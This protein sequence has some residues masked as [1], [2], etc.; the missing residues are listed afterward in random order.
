[1]SGNSRNSLLRTLLHVLV[2]SA[3]LAAL[4]WEVIWQ[5]KSSLALGISAWGTALTLAATMGGMSLGAFVMGNA[6]KN[7]MLVR[8]VRLYGALEFAI[9]VAGLFLGQAFKAVQ[10]LDTWAYTAI[11]GNGSLVH[12][13]G[14]AVV[15]G[16]P[17]M[18]MGA[19]LPVFGL[20]ARQFRTSI[21]T[22]YGLNTL[23][24]ATGSLI[25]AFA[26][27]PLFGIT[28]TGF[29]A[30]G[31]NFAVGVAT[32]LLPPGEPA[33]APVQEEVKSPTA[34]VL[35]PWMQQLIVTVTG[36]A[37][38]VLEIAW[39]R[40]L[41]AAF[42]S[43][44]AAFATMLAAVLI[45]LG[46]AARLAPILKKGNIS[47]GP[48]I[49]W[50]GILI[51]LATPIIERFELFMG[52]TGNPHISVLV[53]NMSRIIMTLCVVGPPVLFLGMA[54]P[55]IIDDTDNAR[56][57]GILY[58]LNTLAAIVGS[59]SAAWILLPSIGFARTAWL[60]GALVAISGIIASPSRKRVAL[61]VLSLA[62][63]VTA[64]AL[65]SGASRIYA[66]GSQRFGGNRKGKLLELYEGPMST[67][68]VTEYDNG[69]RR[70]LIDGSS[71][72]AQAGPDAVNYSHY[73]RWTGRLPMILNPDP[74]NVLIICFG[75]GQTVNAVRRENPKSIDVVDINPDIFKLAHNFPAN[76]D[77][78]SD[79]KVK[80]IVMDG[81]AYM[82]RIQKTYDVITLEPMPPTQAG[83]NNLYS[84]EFY[85]FARNRLSAHGTIA[86]WLPFYSVPPKYAASIAKTFHDVFPNSIIWMD[87]VTKNDGILL[88]TKDDNGPPLG[89]VWPGL[90]RKGTT[91]DMSPD[92]IRNDVYLNREEL[93]RYS[94]YGETITDDNQ[95]LAYGEPVYAA[96]QMLPGDLA[97][98]SLKFIDQMKK[99]PS[100]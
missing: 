93:A 67:V 63:L 19:T 3:G 40:S 73:M 10:D 77:V 58:T 57:W 70:L 68:S 2:A 23:G 60:A 17:T 54:F 88:G 39:F 48:I 30:A 66:Q 16:V 95:L 100:P 12:I 91:R 85:E 22:L 27:I 8:P 96:S 94:K 15:I 97:D 34:T 43:T 89:T 7:R 76:E 52:V 13:L 83:V 38:F 59:I 87:P 81:R 28:H 75:T 61:I 99:T 53:M 31:I 50:A 80:H 64:A 45:A 55:W 18:C 65:Q 29:I 20:V 21:A 56:R 6:L 25:A 4:S 74:K 49:G 79:P 82:R 44:T 35:S 42:H 72:S 37:T 1:M 33:T 47:L 86:Q 24:A 5:N 36:F 71:A 14:I 62:A 26:L 32:W 9:G 41:T 78:L 46:L 98:E 84:K 92:E 69:E 90:D 11:P 51:L